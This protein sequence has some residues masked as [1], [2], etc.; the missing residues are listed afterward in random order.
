MLAKGES[1]VE[2]IA[3]LINQDTSLATQT[4]KVANSAL[5]GFRSPAGNIEEAILRTGSREI[6]R[7]VGLASSAILLQGDHGIY[8][9]TPEFV[10]EHSV[11][12]AI[13]ME[14]I[15]SRGMDDPA[16]AYTIGLLRPLGRI[17]IA[18]HIKHY[19]LDAQFAEGSSVSVPEWEKGEFGLNYGDAGAA[20]CDF[21]RFPK[22]LGVALRSHFEPARNPVSGPLPH[23]LNF[24]CH[25]VGELGRCL[26]GEESLYKD[27]PLRFRKTGVGPEEV[28][29]LTMEV[30]LEFDKA[31]TLLSL[32]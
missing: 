6:Q 30:I 2:E 12:T 17:I 28:D 21:W 14:R 3:R 9:T 26:P 13:A 7:L 27:D 5:Y 22:Q 4:L 8:R 16:S 19:R 11:M 32:M 24:A 18:Q 29:D 31:K 23:M 1:S 25:I 15:A 10:W 20:A